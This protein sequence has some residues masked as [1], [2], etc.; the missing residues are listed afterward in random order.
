MWSLNISPPLSCRSGWRTN[1]RQ[2]SPQRWWSV[3]TR[4]A[5]TTPSGRWYW[6]THTGQR[7]KYVCKVPQLPQVEGDCKACYILTQTHGS[8]IQICVLWPPKMLSDEQASS[9]THCCDVTMV[10]ITTDLKLIEIF[11][12]CAPTSSEA[13]AVSWAGNKTSE[14]GWPTSVRFPNLLWPTSGRFLDLLY[15]SRGT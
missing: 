4:L 13:M 10:P 5:S 15:V 7:C 8:E 6:L 3:S 12:E 11:P 14:V 2:S 9:M 1:C